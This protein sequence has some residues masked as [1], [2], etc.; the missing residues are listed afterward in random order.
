MKKTFL[1]SLLLTL[2][3]TVSAWAEFN[4]EA[5]KM[6]ALKE[7]TTGL[8]LDIQTLGIHEPG[9]TTNSMSLNSKLCII[10]FEAGAEG[11][12]RLKNANGTYGGNFTSGRTWNTTIGETPYDWIIIEDAE[13]GISIAKDASN[14][15]GWDNGKNITAGSALYN[16]AED[17]NK[18][19][20]RIYFTLEEYTGK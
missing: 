17:G 13:K 9:H 19:A 7:K 6:Y 5:G 1:L 11:K 14:Y 20:S 10:Y 4:P 12:W 2:L 3:G 15:I 8:Y 16:N 18:G